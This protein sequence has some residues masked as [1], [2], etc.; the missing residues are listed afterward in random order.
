MIDS[1]M[2]NDGFPEPRS[3]KCHDGKLE[4]ERISNLMRI[5]PQGRRNLLEIGARDGRVTKWLTGYYR[6]VIALDI[7]LPTFKLPHVSSLQGN[8][9]HLPFAADSFDTVLCTE[10]LEHIPHPHLEEACSEIQRV[11]KYEVIVGVPFRQDLRAGRTTCLSCGRKN[12]PWGHVNSFDEKRLLRL[13]NGLTPAAK[14]FVGWKKDVTNSVSTMLLDLAGNPWGIYEQDEPCVY[15]GK[16]L[17]TPPERTFI[18]RGFSAAAVSLT[19]LQQRFAR[20]TPIWIHVVLIKRDIA[21][22]ES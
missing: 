2:K 18:Q 9:A 4:D 3:V 12:P 20:P 14:S 22:T 11:A 8:A 7:N 6:S 17:Q 1:M 10:V 15:C 21:G 13:F 16:K 19:R 5:I